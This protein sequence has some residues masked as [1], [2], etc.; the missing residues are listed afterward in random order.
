MIYQQHE[1]ALKLVLL[2]KIGQKISQCV[3]YILNYRILKSRNIINL[4]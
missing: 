2:L 1:N 3:T 4:I